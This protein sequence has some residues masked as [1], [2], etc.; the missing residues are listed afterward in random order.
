MDTLLSAE[1]QFRYWKAP[2]SAVLEIF[3]QNFESG[4]TSCLLSSSGQSS[5]KKSPCGRRSGVTLQY[6]RRELPL[7]RRP[8]LWLEIFPSDLVRAPSVSPPPPHPLCAAA[9]PRGASGLGEVPLPRARALATCLPSLHSSMGNRRR[10]RSRAGAGGGSRRGFA[11]SSPIPGLR[12]PPLP[13]REERAHPWPSALVLGPWAVYGGGRAEPR[14]WGARVRA[15]AWRLPAWRPGPL[16]PAWCGRRRAPGHR[17]RGP[18]S[19][20]RLYPRGVCI[21]P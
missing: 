17:G 7:S 11:F 1:R 5:E 9:G 15:A 6:L 3:L 12:L 13:A 8:C 14:L 4:K 18:G 19:R 20:A 21:A 10:R 16:E 2:A